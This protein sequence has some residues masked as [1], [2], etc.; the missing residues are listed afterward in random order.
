[1]NRSM[2]TSLFI[3]LLC[4]PVQADMENEPASGVKLIGFARLGA[5]EFVP[6]RCQSRQKEGVRMTSKV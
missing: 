2:F 3:F 5:D 4:Q 6:G 1:M